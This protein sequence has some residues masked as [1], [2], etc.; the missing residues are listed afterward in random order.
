MSLHGK[1]VSDLD[2]TQAVSVP[3]ILE[4]GVLLTGNIARSNGRESSGKSVERPIR[5]FAEWPMLSEFNMASFRGLQSV[6]AQCLT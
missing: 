4:S 3:S 6:R 5:N 1:A 2:F